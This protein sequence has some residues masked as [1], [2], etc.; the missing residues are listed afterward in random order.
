MTALTLLQQEPD[1]Q[2]A[3]VD[4]EDQSPQDHRRAVTA[5]SVLQ[6]PLHR[7]AAAPPSYQCRHLF[8]WTLLHN[9]IHDRTNVS[10]PSTVTTL[11]PS[12]SDVVGKTR[13]EGHLQQYL[14]LSSD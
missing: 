10:R 5:A 3:S 2:E 13:F 14:S 12:K 6:R 4:P 11:S 9:N 7:H 1:S 8:K